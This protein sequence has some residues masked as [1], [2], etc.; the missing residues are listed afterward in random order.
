MTATLRDDE[1]LA[2]V[3]DSPTARRIVAER[4]RA[5]AKRRVELEAERAALIGRREAEAPRLVAAIHQAEERFTAE[6]ARLNERTAALRRARYAAGGASA[7]FDHALHRIDAE[8][9][10]LEK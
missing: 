2:I 10:D 7:S 8:L 3:R 6:S 4:D 9:A 1:L 5:R